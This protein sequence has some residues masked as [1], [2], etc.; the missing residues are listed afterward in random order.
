MI[1]PF[2]S[3]TFTAQLRLS[4]RSLPVQAL[5][6]PMAI[7]SGI[8]GC[9]DEVVPTGPKTSPDLE[10]GLLRGEHVVRYAIEYPVTERFR[11]KGSVDAEGNCI[12]GATTVVSP[13]Q[14]IFESIAEYDPSTCEAVI[15]RH[16]P[17]SAPEYARVP[18]TSAIGVNEATGSFGT[19]REVRHT[20]AAPAVPQAISQEFCTEIGYTKTAGQNI[21]FADPVGKDVTRSEHTAFFFFLRGECVQYARTTLRSEWFDESGWVLNYHQ[22]TLEPADPQYRRVDS[23]GRQGMRNPSFCIGNTTWTDYVSDIR[24]F[25]D[26]YVSFLWSASATGGCSSFLT[27]HRTVSG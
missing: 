7:M 9:A 16:P 6:L 8:I 26:G 11:E 18:V 14:V 23:M 25:H 3:G 17:E 22:H 19:T 20:P 13:G 10:T 15:V 12:F 24:M 2:D 5:L 27:R 4:S 21:W 1:R